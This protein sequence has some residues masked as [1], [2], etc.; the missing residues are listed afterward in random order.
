MELGSTTTNNPETIPH[1]NMP[2]LTLKLIDEMKK[3]WLAVSD[4]HK[5]YRRKNIL[6]EQLNDLNIYT[7]RNNIEIRNIPE[8]VKDETHCINVLASLNI[9]VKEYD[10]VGVLRL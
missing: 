9:H 7:G 10:I 4:G 2:N 3:M 5:T 6:E 8:T 1:E